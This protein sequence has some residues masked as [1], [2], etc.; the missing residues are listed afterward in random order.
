MDFQLSEDQRAFADMAQSLFADY[1]TDDKLR[2]HDASGQPFMQDLWQQCVAAGLHSILVPEA[3]GGLGLGM[4]EML[5]VLEQQGRALAQVPLWQQQVAAAAIARFAEGQ[6]AVVQSAMQGELL[7]L[8]L[9]AAVATR[10]PALEL[11]GERLKGQLQAVPL[12][13]QARVALVAAAAGDEIKLVL[14]SL[15]ADGV[16]RVAGMREDYCAV[17]DISFRNTP[18]LAVLGGRALDWVNEMAIACLASLQQG[19]TQ[20]QLRRTVEYVS[21][22]KQFDRPIGTFQLV[23]GQMADGYILM[24][25]QRG[26]LSQLVWRLDAGLPCVPQAHAVRAQSNELGLKVGRVAQHVHGG[27]GVDVTYHIHRFMFWCRALAAELGSA[28]Q[29][30]QALGQWL[31]D[32]DTLGWKYDLP[33]DR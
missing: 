24:Q 23:Q 3:A 6:G 11:Q 27:M 20:E 30:L 8:S 21:E 31:A 29:H 1:C 4:S 5:A 2:E 19:V 7:A 16:S 14:V 17:A 28:E 18:V 12:G 9:Q 13:E 10:G 32:N 33:E 25:A 22:R 15:Q 26:A